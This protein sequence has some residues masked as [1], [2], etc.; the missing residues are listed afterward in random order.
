MVLK[1]VHFVQLNIIGFN[2]EVVVFHISQGLE[3]IVAETVNLIERRG[4]SLE[5]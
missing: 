2:K 3:A 5:H 1:I 4:G